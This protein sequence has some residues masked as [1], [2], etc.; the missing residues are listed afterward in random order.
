MKLSFCRLYGIRTT[1][2]EQEVANEIFKSNGLF[3][4]TGVQRY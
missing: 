4:G 3:I 1:L 2:E